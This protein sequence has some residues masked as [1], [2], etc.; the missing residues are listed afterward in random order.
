MKS[1]SMKENTK[2]VILNLRFVIMILLLC[3]MSV[4]SFGQTPS[5][6]EISGIVTDA[7][8]EALIG[9]SV[10][11]V[12]TN[13]GVI[14]D[15]DGHYKIL[16]VP[17][18]TLR[19]SY[20]GYEPV[21]IKLTGQSVVN[22]TMSELRTDLDEVVVVGYGTVK[23]RDLTGSVAS[24]SS[25]KLRQSPALSAAEAIQG[26]VAGALVAN[27]AW[28][29][30][31]TPSILIRGKRSINASN[32]PLYVIDGIPVST[33]PAMF[34]V[35]DIESIDVLKD[36][37]ATAIYGSRGANGVILIT[38]KKGKAGKTQ[39]SYNGYYGAQTIQNK[40]ELMNGAEFAEYV[41]ESHRAA[42]L[43]DSPVPNIDLDKTLTSFTGDAYTWESIAMAYDENGNYDPSKVRSG[44]LWWKEVER[45]GIVTDHQ[46]NARGGTENAQYSLG[47]TYYKNEGIYKQQ[48]YSRYSVD[49]SID[50]E[51][52]KWLKIGGNTHYINSSQNRGT[53]FQSSWRVNPLGRLYNDDGTP[54][55][56]TSGTDTQWWNPLQYLEPNAVVNP[57]K[58]HR[59][60]GSY[61]G[62]V[63]LPLDGL[64]YRANL[65]IDFHSRQ[66]YSFASANARTA[67]LSLAS[68]ATQD[69]YAYTIENLLYYDKQFGSHSFNATLLQSVQENKAQSLSITGQDFP[70]DDLLYNDMASA[71]LIT[72]YDSNNQV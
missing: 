68:N 24:I 44:A 10:I 50:F 11:E 38:T 30:G 23:K 55:L 1:K 53:A 62:E 3:S 26:K 15:M 13:N 63:K 37:S 32:D 35:G 19:F 46:L 69:T 9:V 47:V 64:R 57:L 71:A 25:E 2:Q 43:Y 66:D 59:F 56:M 14:T 52:T 51:A 49:A 8:G 60:M 54:T 22:V 5:A 72:A 12:G 40:Q 58:I 31:A 6:R 42:G 34:S 61:Y 45:T 41:R 65:G 29:P 17:P 21:D 48:D 67:T 36:A 4:E 20:L 70:S 39:L 7:S 27:T 28:T 16:S 18:V 33:A